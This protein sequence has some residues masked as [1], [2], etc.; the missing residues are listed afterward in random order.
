M[1]DLVRYDPLEH[2]QL[3]G[4]LK[5]YYGLTQKEAREAADDTALTRG[6][7]NSMRSARMAWN[8]FTGDKEEFSQL[9]AEDM[10]YRKIQEGRKSEARRELGEAWEKG[11]GVGGGLSNVWGELKKDWREKG[12]DGV[13]ED[14]G[15]MGVRRWS[16]RLMRLFRLLRQ[17]SV[18]Q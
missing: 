15:E 17:P 1:S 8:D 13:L 9:K 16:R 18:E 5:K 7:N 12:L 3:V 10:D 2:G 4:G 11:E 14:V 6:F